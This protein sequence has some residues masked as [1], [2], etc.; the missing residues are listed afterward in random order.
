MQ[1]FTP[2]SDL[3]EFGLIQR[4][5]ELLGKPRNPLLK[6][7]GDDAAVY[8]VTD[9]RVHV[10][11]S[12]MLIEN[13]HFDRMFHPLRYLGFKAIS[14]NASDVCAMN[15]LPQYA[16][17]SL[18]VPHNMSVEMVEDLYQGVERACALYGMDL[19]GG[20]TTASRQLVISITAIGEAEASQVAYRSG[21]RPGDLVCVTGDVGAAYAGLR[22]LLEEKKRF[23]AAKGEG[24]SPDL[25][26]FDYVIQRSLSPTARLDMVR[27]WRENQIVPSAAIDVSDGLASEINHLCERS[28]VGALLQMA[29]VPIEILTREVAEQFGEDPETFALYGG[30]DY[31]VLFTVT[32]DEAVLLDETLFT[33]IGTITHPEEGLHLELQ[34]GST[35]PIAS[36]GFRH[37]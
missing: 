19:I 27:N 8:P 4:I 15:A 12:D 13:V 18:G 20:D 33:V 11:T 25:S 34:D 31:E 5:G 17:M 23:E 29:K 6:G 9:S 30:D 28:N 16:T 35:M 7:I 21:A 10:V 26:A 36:N 1:H 2:I 14:V 37:F 3:G 22:I 32:P 24:H